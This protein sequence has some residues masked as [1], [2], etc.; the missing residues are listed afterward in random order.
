MEI[1]RYWREQDF[2]Y[3]LAVK[4]KTFLELNPYVGLSKVSLPEDA[5]ELIHDNLLVSGEINV[6]EAM[7]EG[8][9]GK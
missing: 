3:R 4:S 1:P 9:D 7:R 5:L 6:E 2:R 8:V